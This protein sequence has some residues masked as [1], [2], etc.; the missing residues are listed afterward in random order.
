MAMRNFFGFY[1]MKSKVKA[2]D[3]SSKTTPNCGSDIENFRERQLHPDFGMKDIAVGVIRRFEAGD[4]PENDA[5]ERLRALT[6]RKV[7][8]DWLRNY[9]RSESKEDFVDRL[10]SKPIESWQMLTESEAEA[11]ISE[12]LKTSSPGRRDSIEAAIDRRFKRPN[13]TLNDLVFQKNLGDPKKNLDEIEKAETVQ[14]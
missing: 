11:L 2:N 4:Q 14:L 10:C 13:G 8:P 1:S 12:H 6:G 5:L 7:D 3:R 9:W